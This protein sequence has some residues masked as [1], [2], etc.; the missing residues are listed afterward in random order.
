M[1]PKI[2][3][4]NKSARKAASTE[5]AQR[6]TDLLLTYVAVGRLTRRLRHDA[7]RLKADVDIWRSKTGSAD[8]RATQLGPVRHTSW[9]AMLPDGTGGWCHCPPIMISRGRLCF[10]VGCDEKIRMC[11]WMCFDLPRNGTISKSRRHRRSRYR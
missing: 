3:K 6:I 8:I 7:F 5:L 9:K 1:T 10:L 2:R 4:T 11:S